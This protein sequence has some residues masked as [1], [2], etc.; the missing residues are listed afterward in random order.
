VQ[1]ISGLLP[2]GVSK[3][4]EGV[5]GVTRLFGLPVGRFRVEGDRFVY[6]AWPVVDEVEP[7]PDGGFV[8]AGLLFGRRFCRF[9]LVRD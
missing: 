5:Q 7:T 3:R 6:R 1:R 2:P 8:G 4:I 9:R